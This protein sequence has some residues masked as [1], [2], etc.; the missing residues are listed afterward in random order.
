MKTVEKVKT[1]LFFAWI[2]VW[3]VFHFLTPLKFSFSILV[4]GWLVLF[5]AFIFIP[6]F[7]TEFRRKLRKKRIYIV[8]PVRKLTETERPVILEYVAKLEA[9]GCEVHCPFRDTDQVDEIGLRITS[10]H[11]VKDIIWADEIHI[12]WNPTSQGSLFDFAQAR[13]AGYFTP[14]KIILINVN[15]IEIDRDSSGRVIKSYTNVLLATHFGLKPGC[16][17]K[18]LED[19]KSGK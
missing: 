10:E 13:M 4:A 1:V 16:T 7:N 9:Q 5:L 14:K 3:L 2:I 17:A 6:S 12:W 11:E 8:C 15:A 19:K 18:D